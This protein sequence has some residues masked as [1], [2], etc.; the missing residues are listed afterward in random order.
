[1]RNEGNVV[2]AGERTTADHVMAEPAPAMQSCHH[3]RNIQQHAFR[4]PLQI[5]TC[6]IDIATLNCNFGIADSS[7]LDAQEHT[8]G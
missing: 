1:M 8:L 2:M 7:A 3:M 5:D 4:R 6:T